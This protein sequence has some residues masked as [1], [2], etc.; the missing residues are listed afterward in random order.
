MPI[1]IGYAWVSTTKQDLDRQIDALRK[2]GIAAQRIY[3]DQNS[4][5]NTNRPGLQTAFD[6]ARDRDVI[7]VHVQGP[8]G[9]HREELG[10]APASSNSHHRETGALLRTRFVIALSEDR[11]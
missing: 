3:V 8:A 1:W 4:G 11:T 7:V 6:Q 9:P 10:L 2:E 5:A